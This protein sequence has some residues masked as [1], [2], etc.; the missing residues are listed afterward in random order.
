MSRRG[1]AV[2]NDDVIYRFRLRLFGLAEELGNVR[3]A[4]RTMGLHPVMRANPLVIALAACQ[5]GVSGASAEACG[6][7]EKSVNA[8][9]DFDWSIVLSGSVESMRDIFSEAY[10]FDLTNEMQLA[11][12]QGFPYWET[13]AQAYDQS[14]AS[15]AMSRGL[16]IAM[17]GLDANDVYE[18]WKEGGTSAAVEETAK[19]GVSTTVGY[20]VMAGCTA[21]FGIETFG[22]GMVGCIVLGGAAGGVTDYALH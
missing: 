7:L 9:K 6:Q 3:A 11:Q 19:V 12:S 4:C 13:R 14:F 20:A 5:L 18:A 22:A 2:V 1:A 21:A 15:R 17:L 8:D 10:K 16:L